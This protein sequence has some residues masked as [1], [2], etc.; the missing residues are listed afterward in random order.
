MFGGAPRAHPATAIV[1]YPPTMDLAELRAQVAGLLDEGWRRFKLPIAPTHEATLERL[2]TVRAFGDELWLGL[3]ANWIFKRSE[4]AIAYIRT[5]EP[6]GLGWVEDI[7]PPGHAQDIATVRGAVGV[8]IGMGDEQGGA[9]HPEALV[10]ADAVDVVR[11]D[12]STNGGVTGL[13]R[14]LAE[15]GERRFTTHM[16]PHVHSRL[17]SGLGIEGVP[18]E[19]GILGNGVDQVSD[20]FSRPVV[21]DGLMQPLPPEPGFGMRIDPEWL[22]AQNPDDPDDLIGAL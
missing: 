5:L 13:R 20:T 6:F 1:G 19:W 17:F 10:M 9:Y 4:D 18:I 21:V 16:F 3:D 22:R 14:V 11:V 7:M 12:A 2:A 15:L 8:P